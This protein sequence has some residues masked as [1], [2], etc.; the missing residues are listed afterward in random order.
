MLLPISKESFTLKK[1]VNLVSLCFDSQSEPI[2]TI[3]D[4]RG[5]LLTLQDVVYIVTTTI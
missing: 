4:S 1:S 5:E 3:R 2:A